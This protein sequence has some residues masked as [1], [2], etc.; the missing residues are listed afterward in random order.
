[1]DGSLLLPPVDACDEVRARSF[2]ELIGIGSGSPWEI[3]SSTEPAPGEP[4]DVSAIGEELLCE[5]TGLLAR[6]GVAVEDCSLAMIV[7][8]SRASAWL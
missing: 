4:G 7:C 8:C 2:G 6:F 5:D 1:M 3:C